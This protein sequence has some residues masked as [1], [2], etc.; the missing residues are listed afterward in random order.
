MRTKKFS[1]IV[2]VYNCQD[3]ISRCIESVLSQTYK[4]LEL[5][6]VND[7]SIDNSL[8]IIKQY[9]KE[10]K[11]II[12]INKKNEGVSKARNVALDKATGHFVCFLDA[13]DY[14]D[15]NF[16][17]ESSKIYSK[18]KDLEWLGFGYYSEIED[19]NQVKICADKINYKTKYYKTLNTLKKDF[20]ELWDNTVFYNIV[21]KVFL[22]SII[23]DNKI[24][25]PKDYFGEDVKFNR[26]YMNHISNFYNSE[27]C[28]YHY[29]RER[30][31][32][33]TKKYKPDFFD[34]RK[35]EFSEFNEYFELWN[36]KKDKYYEYSCRRYIER[37]LGCIENVYCSDMKFGERYKKI[38]EMITDE[39]TREAIKYIVPTS[40]KVKIMIMPI[41]FKL[42]LITMLMGKT[43]NKIKTSNPSF[44]NKLKNRR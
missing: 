17:E 43:I 25:F 35:K 42:V 8:E 6:I 15:L 33:V 44:F 3:Y 34:I 7:G 23:V 1:I 10:D 26:E 37:L 5:I 31:G 16:L 24:K 38:K 27:D 41:K 28:Y 22:R 12:V 20:V 19:E 30:Q 14:L 13:D 11:R 2:P 36:I 4:N 18:N 29:I 40:K 32:A 9:A 21:N 39:T